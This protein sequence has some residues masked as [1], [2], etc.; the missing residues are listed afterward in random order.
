MSQG[1]QYWHAMR[2]K[3]QRMGFVG[4]HAGL[5]QDTAVSSTTPRGG[6]GCHCPPCPA[7]QP[8]GRAASTEPLM[9]RALLKP[10]LQ[11]TM[12]HATE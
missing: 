2:E 11:A 7:A 10:V 1:R 12:S 4:H 5:T 8:C 9:H 6:L 3:S